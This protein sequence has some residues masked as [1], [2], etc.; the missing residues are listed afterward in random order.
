M[1]ATH[2]GQA[3]AD[4][5]RLHRALRE[6]GYQ[7][8]LTM[9]HEYLRERRRQRAEVYVPLVHHPGEAQVDFFEVVVEVGGERRKAWKFLLRLMYSGR[10]FAWLYERCDQLAFLDGHV[11]AFANLEGVVRRCVYDYVARH[12]I[13]VMCPSRLCCAL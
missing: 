6:D 7:V 9:I 8:G 10:E 4:R 12:I 2:D 5:V 1:G 13:V 11:R 3:A